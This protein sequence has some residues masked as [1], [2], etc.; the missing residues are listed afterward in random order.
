MNGLLSLLASCPLIFFSFC[1]PEIPKI[2]RFE[3]SVVDTAA[4]ESPKNTIQA[5]DAVNI[6]HKC[7]RRS[8][9]SIS[10]FG[11][12][13]LEIPQEF[14]QLGA[15]AIGPDAPAPSA[16]DLADQII[17]NF[18]Y[19]SSCDLRKFYV[20]ASLIKKLS[21]EFPMEKMLHFH[22]TSEDGDIIDCIDIYKQPAFDHPALKHHKIQMAPTYNTNKTKMGSMSVTFQLW[23]KSGRCPEGT[24]HVRRIR[25]RDLL[26]AHSIE[27]YGRKNP[28]ISPQDVHNLDSL[29]SVELQNHSVCNTFIFEL[30]DI[31]SSNLDKSE[32]IN[33]ND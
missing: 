28:S 30:V 22:G 20:Q 21:F 33:E 10:V 32:L 5:A 3:D 15:A 1:S 6:A 11:S 4:G 29:V 12:I 24:I 16:E 25:K 23:Q 7:R 26:K 19:F 27:D 13:C 2:V 17:E 14:L 31:Y 18:N 8:L 9:F